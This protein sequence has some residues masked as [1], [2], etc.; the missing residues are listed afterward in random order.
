MTPS[1][2]PTR[3]LLADDAIGRLRVTSR[4]TAAF[5]LDFIALARGEAHV[6]D[7]L[8]ASAIIQANVAEI[9]R[10]A[11]LA[12]EYAESDALPTDEMRRPVSMNAVASSLNLPFE[13]VRRRVSAMAQEGFCQ[14][15]DGGVIVPTAVLAQP[16]YYIAAYKGYERLRA[17]YYQLRDLGLLPDLPP[18]TVDLAAGTFPIRAASRLVGSYVL[19]IVEAMGMAGAIVEGNLIDALVLMEVFRSNV[20]HLS[21]VQ[22]GGE[23]F[24]PTDMVSDGQR[25]PVSISTVARRLG[26]PHETVRRRASDL[27]KRG[28][29]ARTR[30]GLIIPA[31]TLAHPALRQ[32]LGGN[33][34]NLQ[35][36]F[37]ALARLGVM[38]VWDGLPSNAADFEPG[39]ALRP[40]GTA[41]RRSS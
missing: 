32:Q 1:A 31:R 29:C 18:A 19:R 13:T 6:L 40:S 24:D 38:Q 2:V 23:G 21:H 3:A 35:R 26:L 25:I 17:F 39:V 33:A 34:A 9:S 12:V 27:V 11:D 41:A 4:L 10:H 36:L 20:E 37:S 30:G 8:L 5:L 28:V 7:A 14:F 15:V 16:Q 22:R